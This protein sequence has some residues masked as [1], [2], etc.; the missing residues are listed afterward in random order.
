MATEVP[1]IENLLQIDGY[2]RTH[3][4]EIKRRFKEFKSKLDVIDKAEGKNPA[5]APIYQTPNTN[6]MMVSILILTFYFP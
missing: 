3:E 4:Y 6:S 1:E 5:K 2:L